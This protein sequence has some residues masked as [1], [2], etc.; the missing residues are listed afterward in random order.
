MLEATDA[1]SG[2][3][4][5]FPKHETT[6]VMTTNAE[7]IFVPTA[8]VPVYLDFLRDYLTFGRRLAAIEGHVMLDYLLGMTL[9]EVNRIR[10]DAMPVFDGNGMLM[11]TK[12][13]RSYRVRH[14]RTP[15]AKASDEAALPT[16]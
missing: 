6:T 4:S 9:E 16:P 11:A 8:T 5:S 13:A 12:G 15:R 10:P 3:P 2:A 1:P 14:K 7:R